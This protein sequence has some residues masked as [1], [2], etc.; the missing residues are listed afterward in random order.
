MCQLIFQL[1]QLRVFLVDLLGVPHVDR[2]MLP[3][4]LDQHGLRSLVDGGVERDSL[5]AICGGGLPDLVCKGALCEQLRICAGQEL[6][7]SAVR[8]LRLEDDLV[9]HN[10]AR[11]VTRQ[12]KLLRGTVSLLRL[13]LLLLLL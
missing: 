1:L 8:L 11:F 6:R 12:E 9:T 2:R 4:F 5:R 3:L 7:K 13:Q 10:D